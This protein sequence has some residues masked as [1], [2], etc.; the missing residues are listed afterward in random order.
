MDPYDAFNRWQN[1]RVEGTAS[2]LS[3]VL[4]HLDANLPAGWRKANRDDLP[5]P[6]SPVEEGAN[7]YYLD[8]TPDHIA[9]GVR[10]V[11]APPS[12]L[13]GGQ[14]WFGGSR[15]PLAKADSRAIWEQIVRFL[16]RGIKPA[17]EGV[18]AR[19]WVP[20]TADLFFNGLPID[21]RDFLQTFSASSGKTFPLG[22]DALGLWHDFVVSA[23][24]SRTRV[25]SVPM[26]EWLIAQGWPAPGAKE[27]VS[28][29][30]DQCQLLTRYA[31]ELAV[32]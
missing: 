29:F 28:R 13:R 1:W 4:E 23:F 16:D 5:E 32:V 10:V 2:Q 17:A 11:P 9:V 15:R 8:A 26:Q 19:V 21:I 30:Y 3:S 31:E 12:G 6:E 7:S 24:R 27:L 14:F 20:S 18:A 25:E 22:R